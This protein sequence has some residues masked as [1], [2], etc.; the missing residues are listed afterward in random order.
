MKWNWKGTRAHQPIGW[1]IIFGFVLIPVPDPF[2]VIYFGS[3]KWFT[4][5]WTITKYDG[6]L[7]IHSLL[8]CRVGWNLKFKFFPNIALC[9]WVVFLSRKNKQY[10]NWGLP[11]TSTKANVKRE[12]IPK[13]NMALSALDE[14]F[15]NIHD[16]RCLEEIQGSWCL[17]EMDTNTS[18]WFE[19][20]IPMQ[21]VSSD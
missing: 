14:D 18:E 4:V 3:P 11:K 7:E 20:W 19:E 9:S 6:R 5:S 13:L 12:M 21:N 2:S 10:T 15:V 1:I 8:K 17:S 16:H